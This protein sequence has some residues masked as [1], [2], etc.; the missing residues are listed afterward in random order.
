MYFYEYLH[1]TKSG[2]DRSPD[3]VMLFLPHI[4][5]IISQ[6]CR[7]R[8]LDGSM[9][10]RHFYCTTRLHLAFLR[11]VL[12]A[13]D[14]RVCYANVEGDRLRWK[15]PACTM[16]FY[17]QITAVNYIKFIIRSGQ[18]GTPVPTSLWVFVRKIDAVNYIKFLCAVLGQSATFA[19][20]TM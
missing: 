10:Q 16:R 9:S 7:D 18:S 11:E 4:A 6:N 20:R 2:D 1:K 3:V 15:E 19:L 13:S 5:A 8:R 17:V 14:C 12:V